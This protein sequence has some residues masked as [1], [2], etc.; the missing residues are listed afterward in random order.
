MRQITAFVPATK[1]LQGVRAIWWRRM[2]PLVGDQLAHTGIMRRAWKAS[3]GRL[4]THQRISPETPPC[5]KTE[6]PVVN[7][8]RLCAE[9]QPQRVQRCRGQELFHALL[10]RHPLRLVLRTQPRSVSVV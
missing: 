10:K 8:A 3:F 9:H 5:C 2:T 4:T 7:G 1:A 6:V